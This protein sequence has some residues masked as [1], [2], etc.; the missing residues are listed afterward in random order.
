VSTV[1]LLTVGEAFEDLIF[2]GLPRLP[3]SGE[4][5]KTSTFVRTVGGGA[6]I[7]AVAAARLGLRVRVLSG[8]ADAAEDVLRKERVTTCN[9]R[10]PDEPPA[11]SA[12]LSTETNRAFVTFNGV[13]DYLEPRLMSALSRTGA[14]HVHLAFFPRDC[15][16]WLPVVQKLRRQRIGTSWDFGW[17]EDLQRDRAFPALASSVDFLML[18][19]QEVVLYSGARRLDEAVKRWK[20]RART[21]IIKRGARGS[22][23]ISATEDIEV[24]AT[25]VKV[26]DT[27]GAG[28][29]FNGG[30]LYAW[31]SDMP[32]RACLKIANQVGAC[33]TRAAGGLAGLPHLDELT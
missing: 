16:R 28:D 11:I 1:D 20:S 30:F 12:A 7:T 33:S 24:P 10:R 22:R 3:R 26:V 8:L 2:V 21:L 6:V 9:L 27:T 17:N 13:N 25:R 32:P 18:N 14:R 15:H 19:D 5:I 29:A 23:W 4:E 31:L